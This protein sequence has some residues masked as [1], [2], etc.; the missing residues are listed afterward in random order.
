MTCGLCHRDPE[1]HSLSSSGP[2]RCQYKTHRHAC[3]ANFTT[4]CS[5]HVVEG[6]LAPPEDPQ[7]PPVEPKQ[8]EK[9]E[10]E[11]LFKKLNVSG[12]EPGPLQTPNGTPTVNPATTPSGPPTNGNLGDHLRNMVRDHVS[13]N[14]QHLSQQT[15]SL[16]S[17]QGPT[18]GQIRQNPDVKSQADILMDALKAA[19]PVFS[20]NAAS[21]PA[22]GIA[23]IHPLPQVSPHPASH[24]HPPQQFPSQTSQQPSQLTPGQFAPQLAQAFATPQ[25]T[26][27]Q[28]SQFVHPVQP[29]L[30]ATGQAQAQSLIHGL[31]QLLGQAVQTPT[32]PP[33]PPSQDMSLLQG[34]QQLLGQ[35]APPPR[36][37]PPT[38]Q[39]PAELLS[40]LAQLGLGP[41]NTNPQQVPQQT[42]M[43][44]PQMVHS[45]SL[46]QPT[47]GYYQ[48]NQQNLQQNAGT[49]TTIPSAAKCS[50]PEV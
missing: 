3:P 28:N 38:P 19:L 24:Q 11:N 23:G 39:L 34:L 26:A 49:G 27:Q 40:A 8:E 37:P 9:L 17:Y 50:T 2:T 41:L 10:I 21:A 14:Q 29:Q 45:Q 18:I 5:D 32:Q 13:N 16:G 30:A 25:F 15:P 20:Q 36:Q 42:Q 47:Q 1:N 43:W 35:T 31:Q 12:Q 6:A 22:A 7:D 48:Q 44:N 46:G 4:K 33:P